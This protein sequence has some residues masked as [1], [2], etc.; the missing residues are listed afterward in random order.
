MDGWRASI[1]TPSARGGNR[2]IFIRVQENKYDKK[3]RPAPPP[4]AKGVVMRN[5]S[6]TGFCIVAA[7]ALTLGTGCA[8]ALV[9]PG[10]RGIFFDPSSGG[11]QHE[12]LQPGW[13]RTACPLWEPDNKCPRVD[14]FDVTYSTAKEQVHSLSAEKLPLDLHL[15][16]KYRPIVSE[17]YIL[18]TEIGPNYF[19]E[20]VGPEFRSAA[21]GVLARSSYQDLQ[22]ENRAIEDEIEKDLR[23]RLLG[24]HVEVASVLIEK[25]EYAPQI[26][27]AYRQRVVSQEETLTRNQLLENAALQK[28]RELEL[29]AQTKKLE[30][31]SESVQK[32]MELVAQTEQKQMQLQADAEQR[33][34]VAQTETEVKKIEIAKETEEEKARIDSALL[35]KRTEKK[36]AIEQAEIDR[37]KAESDATAKVATARGEADS[38]LALAKAT[39]AENQAG[40]AAITTNQVMMHAYD[41][42][43][44]LGGTGSTFLFGDYSKMPNWLFPKVPGFQTAPWITR[45]ASTDAPPAPTGRKTIPAS[46]KISLKTSPEALPASDDPYED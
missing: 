3:G 23:Q 29:Q 15:A 39:T 4:V 37:L 14:D 24:K 25:I 43:G 35:N 26:V 17:L 31:D 33:K 2:R 20:V 16:L 36:L 27:E 30:L 32:K 6:R 19:D 45:P 7:G 22:K 9:Q 44:Q 34:L 21:I 5:L 8:G 11:I 41:A 46:L 40:A 42:L 10:H 28:K 13:Y 38:R 1:S 12:V 18:D